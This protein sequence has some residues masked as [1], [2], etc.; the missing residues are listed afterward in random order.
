MNNE[1][2]EVSTAFRIYGDNI[3]ECEQFVS[4]LNNTELSGFKLICEKGTLDRPIFI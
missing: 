3:L 1:L 4:W 2:N